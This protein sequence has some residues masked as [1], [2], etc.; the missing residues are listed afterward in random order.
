MGRQG[1]VILG[2]ELFKGDGL[3]CSDALSPPAGYSVKERWRF[4]VASNAGGGASI[5]SFG[6]GKKRPPRWEHLNL[7][8]A[9]AYRVLRQG[10]RQE[11]VA[12]FG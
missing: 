10:G 9:C 12:A 3:S 1:S 5:E 2:L 11:Y 4:E 6:V 7:P 8:A